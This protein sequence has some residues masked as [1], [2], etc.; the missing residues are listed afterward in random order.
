MGKLI[1]K[2]HS[3]KYLKLAYLGFTTVGNRSHL[4]EFATQA[5]TNSNYLNKLYESMSRRMKVV[6][7]VQEGHTKY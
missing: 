6:M 4:L 7:E 3:L 1:L 5:V 2:S